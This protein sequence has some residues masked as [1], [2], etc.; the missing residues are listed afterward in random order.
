[1]MIKLNKNYKIWPFLVVIIGLL[2]TLLVG[3]Y[4][5][6]YYKQKESLQ[7]ELASS[8]IIILIENRMAAYEQVLKSGVGLFKAS[9]N[10]S[11]KEWATFVKEN[12][13]NENFKGI[14]GFGYSEVVLPQNKKEHEARIK[15]EGFP[16]FKIHPDG[17]RELYTSIIYLEPFD[18]RNIRAFG[19]DM[20]SEKVRREA[21]S[22]AMQSGEAT[23]SGKITLVQEF[24]TDVQAGFLM[25][26]PL[27]KKG[28]KTDTPQERTL[29]IQGFVYAPFRANDLMNGIIG[30]QFSNIDFAIY[31]GRSVSQENLIYDFNSIH[32]D[33]SLYKKT[34]ITINGHEWT[35]TFHSHNFFNNEN[36]SMLILIPSFVLILTYLLYLLLNSLIQTREKAQQIAEQ[37]TEKLRASEERVRFAL[38]GTGDGLWDW[39]IKTNEVYF[40]KRWKEMLGFEEEEIDNTL[41]EW[42][43]RVHP[44]DI[45]AVFAD[46]AAHIEGRTDSYSSEHRVKCKD[47]SYKWVLARAIIASRDIDGTPIRMVGSI[48][49]ISERKESQYKIDEYLRI[50]D[51]N[52]ISSTTDLDGT[53][54]KASQALCD[55]S[56][57]S[58]EELI[59]KNH[60]ILRHPDMSNEILEELWRTIKSGKIWNGEIKNRHKDG[61][62]YWVKS[63]I[64]PEYDKNNKM[65]AYSS[66]RHN[67]T[68]QKAKEDFMANMSHELR[69]PL[70]AII[71]FSSILCNKLQDKEA[72]ELAKQISQ[73]SHT[74]L[75]LVNDILDLAKIQD[76]KFS[77]E[78][79]EFHAYEEVIKLSSQLEGLTATKKLTLT[80]HIGDTL[81]GTF[82]GDWDRIKQ[83]ILNLVSNSIKFTPENGMIDIK[84]DYEK[85]LLIIR[86]EDNG[87]GMSNEAQDRIFKPFEQADGSTT[88]K[89]GGTGLGLSITQNL[90]ELMH[91]KIELESVEGKGTIF[92]VQI[93]LEKIN[94]YDGDEP[95]DDVIDE[96]TP[97]NT[98]VLVAE[99]NKTNQMLI[100]MLLDDF[101]VTCDIANDGVEAVEMYNPDIHSLILMD[102]NMPN[103]NGSEAM[104]IIQEKYQERCGPIV[105]LTAN[106]MENDKEKF[107]KLG[108]N[109]YVAKPIDNDELYITMK[110]LLSR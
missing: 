95:E 83:V 69:T 59:G 42:E 8:E 56:G 93:V 86:I 55:I 19:Y 24:D 20:F 5:Y 41:E 78:P 71:G 32:N 28:F 72:K 100:T 68:S 40:S 54:L 92:T 88:R 85:N 45:E 34:V 60:N 27:Y 29:A 70:N 11:R 47:G 37:L 98:H 22:K 43:K 97:L 16:D 39:N 80:T 67:I 53:I 15:R 104:K 38:E 90:V 14:Q 57:Y 107:L 9:Q 74:L 110:E 61:G 13:L 17:E 25:Y 63:T 21:M 30:T 91:G 77:I 96:L 4:T 101:G 58:K 49:D 89:Y 35:I 103:M 82:M 84:I 3:F 62:H 106:A 66:V 18:E 79:F 1:M 50:I 108:M 26:L 7:F 87:I 46:I 76:S 75:D 105:A 109:A 52:V 64:I 10:V 99:D 6:N 48:S 36:S 23:L 81:H 94:E 102:E 12:K 33:T 31:D 65:I 44:E 73:S 2:M 51:K